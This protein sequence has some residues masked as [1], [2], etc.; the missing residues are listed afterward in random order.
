MLRW[1]ALTGAPAYPWLQIFHPVYAPPSP[2]SITPPAPDVFALRPGVD[3]EVYYSQLDGTQ[4]GPFFLEGLDFEAAPV[5]PAPSCF[6]HAEERHGAAGARR[7]HRDSTAL[8]RPC[9]DAWA[10]VKPLSLPASCAR[11]TSWS[12]ACSTR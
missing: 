11:C 4:V 7:G 9:T 6:G 12:L 8:Q 2:P 5:G 3:P 1:E 10:S